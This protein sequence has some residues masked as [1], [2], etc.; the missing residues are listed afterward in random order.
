MIDAIYIENGLPITVVCPLIERRKYFFENYVLPSIKA[1]RPQEILIVTDEGMVSR[2]RNEGFYEASQP[3]IFFCDDDIILPASLLARLLKVLDEN[4]NVGYAYTGYTGIVLHT[5]SHP[6]GE[7]YVI[8]SKEFNLDQLKEQ[9]Y[10]SSMSLFHKDK[11]IPFDESIHRLEDW[12]HYLRLA[13]IGVVGKLL[14]DASFYAFFH[15]EGIT[16]KHNDPIESVRAIH[17]RNYFA[18]LFWEQNGEILS[19]DSLKVQTDIEGLQVIEFCVEQNISTKMV[20]IDPLNAPCAFKILGITLSNHSGESTILSSE[21]IQTNTWINESMHYCFHSDP[22]ILIFG[23]LDFKKIELRIAFEG[24]NHKILP[25]VDS[26]I[27]AQLALEKSR[28]QNQMKQNEKLRLNI[29]TELE[30]NRKNQKQIHHLKKD[31]QDLQGKHIATLSALKK[32][33]SVIKR[34]KKKLKRERSKSKDQ[35]HVL[36]SKLNDLESKLEIQRRSHKSDLIKAKNH[37]RVIQ[38]SLS[39]RIGFAITWPLR[40]T[41]E[42]SLRFWK[43]IQNANKVYQIWR[44]NGKD[45]KRSFSGLMRF[46]KQANYMPMET[47]IGNLKKEINPEAASRIKPI[48]N[49]PVNHSS[50]INFFIDQAVSKDDYVFLSGW[51]LSPH[52]INTIQICSND[53]KFDVIYEFQ[54]DDL[55]AAFPDMPN[56]GNAGF[57]LFIE[58]PDLTV[59]WTLMISDK[60]GHQKTTSIDFTEIEDFD[61][62]LKNMDLTYLDASLQYPIWRCIHKLKSDSP[63]ELLPAR[64]PLISIITPVYNTPKDILDACIS[65][66]LDQVYTNWEL[67]IYDDASTNSDTKECLEFWESKDKRIKI[68]YGTE[69]CHISEASNR[70]ISISTGEYIG[71]LDHDDLL[72]KDAL[73]EVAK[74]IVDNPVAD[75]IY[76]DEDKL[77]SEGQRCQPH[78]KPSWSPETLESMMYL[79][80]FVT[81]KKSVFEQVGGFRKGL[82]G[83]Q[84]YDLALRIAENTDNIYHIPKVLYHWRMSESSVAS[85]IDIKEYAKE[86]AIKALTERLIRQNEVGKV[87]LTEFSGIYE[88]KRTV[89]PVGVD[90]IIPFHN[91]SELTIRCIDSL[92]KSSYTNYHVFLISNNSDKEHYEIIKNHVASSENITL[93]NYDLPFN[94]AAINNWASKQCQSPILLFLNNDTEVLSEDWIE[95]MLEHAVKSTTGVVGAKLLYSDKTIQ[96]AGIVLRIGGLAGHAFRFLPDH[97]PGYCGYAAAVRNCSAVTGAC[98]MISRR[99]F[100]EL[101]GFD[102]DHFHVAYNDVDLCLRALKLGYRNV[103]TSKAVLFHHESKTRPKSVHDMNQEELD[104]YRYESKYLIKSHHEIFEK[105]DPYYNPNLTLKRE[106]YSLDI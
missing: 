81:I 10:I 7:N 76:T 67:C 101:N 95:R 75:Y 78:F 9:N 90:I 46:L 60:M 50:P 24:I 16:S 14:P 49:E 45:G 27:T 22:Q 37:T 20:R 54:R 44:K 69:N 71:F 59:P 100:D 19:A 70:A 91:H 86:A 40:T 13:E 65:S 5:G 56:S 96:H 93:L 35:M 38:N 98:Y 66:V 72:H 94:Y 74:L 87:S 41:Y 36:K 103:Y 8:P 34:T 26:L 97:E 39:N 55:K 62:I 80:H 77:D 82:E 31:I 3:Y 73:F 85:G 12:D 88:I 84:D 83:S 58:L 53:V 6:I 92:K 47:V 105:G 89:D 15:D 18:E 33:Q 102:E 4:P 43:T 99:V 30:E 29:E 64:S 11:L 57:F 17:K 32:S 51:A 21:D 28:N 25:N 42:I 104:Q 63:S 106:N 48:E 1:N 52:K 23:Q 2:Q 79:G 68:L 61:Y